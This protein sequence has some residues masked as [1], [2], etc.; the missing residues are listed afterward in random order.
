MAARF[1]R[2]RAQV[3]FTGEW[4]IEADEDV[5]TPEAA[6]ANLRDGVSFL[7]PESLLSTQVATVIEPVVLCDEDGQAIE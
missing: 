5:S 6:A 7:G 3:T 2:V 1:W 4:F